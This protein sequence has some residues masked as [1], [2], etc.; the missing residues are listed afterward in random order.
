DVN[1]AAF[2][3]FEVPDLEYLASMYTGWRD[4][5][6]YSPEKAEN[7]GFPYTDD[8]ALAKRTAARMWHWLP[9][10]EMWNGDLFCLDLGEP[11]CP[12][13]FN[14]HDWMDGGTGDNGRLMAE[15]FRAFLVGWGSV[16]FQFPKPIYW[17]DCLL[18]S[19]GVAW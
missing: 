9:V 17:P 13:I 7:Y 12:V 11:S 2:A 6:L 14:Q 18:P 4:F 16:C 1:K 3:N 19:G 5:A 15:N 8:P 10:I